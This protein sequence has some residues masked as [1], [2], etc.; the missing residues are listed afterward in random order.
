MK[1]S[2][3]IPIYNVEKYL[4]KC[5][6]SIL[7]DNQFTGQVICVNDGSTDGSLNILKQY[8]RKYPNIEIINQANKGLS[9]A[10][11]AGLR[12][13]VSDY[14]MFVDSDDWL[15]P[16]VIKILCSHIHGEDVLFFNARKFIE[17]TQAFDSE[18]PIME[19][20][21]IEGT[22]Y[23]AATYNKPRNMP[24]VCVWGGVYNRSFLIKNNL[25]NEPGI[26]HEDSYFMPQ[27]LLKAKDVSA[28]NVEVYVY[29]VRQ[30]SIM[31]TISKKHVSDSLFIVRSLKKIYD[32]NN[33]VNI[34]CFYDDL[35]NN[36]IDILQEA[37][38]NNITLWNLWKL[39][40]SYTFFNSAGGKY[41]K[42]IAKLTFL[43]PKLAYKYHTNILPQWLRRMLNRLV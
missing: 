27:V 3:V 17:E 18:M 20:S 38:N 30:G 33:N 7:I 28:I 40:D 12:A 37:Y 14:V 31:T 1:L 23:F 11:N 13:A 43:S 21:H 36:Y 24:C 29:R 39:S 35:A 4:T 10:R 41:K 32:K 9:E 22:A 15:F 26:Y 42:R 16:D 25:W 2:I 6:D 19:F 8:N 34:K 5:L